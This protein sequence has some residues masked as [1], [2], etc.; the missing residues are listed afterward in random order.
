MIQRAVVLTRYDKLAVDDLPDKI[1]NYR[2]SQVVIAGEDPS[3]L[4]PL[5]EVELRY[6]RHVL[7]AVDGNKTL[8]AR[9]LGLDRK[10]LYRKLKQEE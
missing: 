1:R 3:E 2:S 5:E 6:I 9:I 10:T 8:A 7:E 4:L